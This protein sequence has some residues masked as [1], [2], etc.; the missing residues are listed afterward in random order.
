MKVSQLTCFNRQ[1]ERIEPVEAEAVF[2]R[3]GADLLNFFYGQIAAERKILLA[4]LQSEVDRFTQTA[5][6]HPVMKA[7]EHR[8]AREGVW[9]QRQAAGNHE[10]VSANRLR[11]LHVGRHANVDYDAARLQP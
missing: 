10:H 5:R 11:A 4:I 7:E 9:H 8:I 1:P 2:R 6:D 3:D